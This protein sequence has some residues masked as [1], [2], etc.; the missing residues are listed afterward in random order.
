MCKYAERCGDRGPV[1]IPGHDLSLRVNTVSQARM[2]KLYSL[3]SDCMAK[4]SCGYDCEQ[5]LLALDH[6][7][8]LFPKLR[9]PTGL[10]VQ[11]KNKTQNW[12]IH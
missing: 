11:V 1:T 8:E 6:S 3:P 2:Y 4:R 9:T 5:L 12:A 10:M 7:E